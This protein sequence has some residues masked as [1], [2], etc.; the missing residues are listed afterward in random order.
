MEWNGVIGLVS[1]A[2][3]MALGFVTRTIMAKMQAQ[4]IERQASS[5]R[6]EADRDAKS[7]RKEAEIQAR[8]EVLR[9]R[10]KFENE[11][12]EQRRALETLR[13]SL[14]KRETALAEREENLDRKS[15]VLDRK[16]QSIDRKIEAA[17]AKLAAVETREKDAAR[18]AAES[19]AQLQRL[20]G[21]TRDEARRTLF[22]RTEREVRAELGTLVRRLEEDARKDADRTARNIIVD[23]MRRYA[24]SHAS[25]SMTTTVPLSSDSLKGHIIGRDGRNI[26]ALEAA[27]GVTFLVDDTPEAVVISGFDPVRR[28]VARRALDDLLTDGRIHPARIEEAVAKAQHDLDEAMDEAGE[29][30]VAD[31]DLQNVAPEIVRAL[32]RLTFRTSFSQNVLVHSREV[33]ALMGMMASEIGLDAATARRVGLFHDIGKALDH[34]VEGTHAAIGA[35]LLRKNGEAPEVVAGVEFHHEKTESSVYAML[36]ATADAISSAR[37][38]ARTESTEIYLNRVSRLEE[39]ATA[40]PGVKKAFAVQAGRELRVIVDPEAVGDAEAKILAR[41]VSR[42]IQEQVKFPG[43]I[44]V[45]V[46]RET[47]CVEYAR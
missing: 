26:R 30:A 23:A 34:E 14:T 17:D 5:R 45:V 32:G 24:G 1:V 9:V 20:A 42:K 29:Q 36:C 13:G 28:E 47:R 43:Q 2:V 4:S 31:L 6:T 37:P 22:D 7:I 15:T 27:T 33:A 11:V 46:I 19:S 18:L 10:E 41:D 44:R 12:K 25:E 21:M 8:A 3:G 39:I 40:A 35:A 38:G 16:E